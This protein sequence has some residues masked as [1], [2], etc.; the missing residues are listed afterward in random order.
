MND[1]E[2]AVRQLRGFYT[3]KNWRKCLEV[4][5]S[6]KLRLIQE[7]SKATAS[8]QFVSLHREVLEMAVLASVHL[9]DDETFVRNFAQLRAL[10]F[11]SRS[12]VPPSQNEAL[13]T[14]LNLLHLLADNR[15]AEFHTEM[16]LIPEQVQRDSCVAYVVQLEQWLMEGTYRN[17]LAARE[18]MPSECFQ[19][20]LDKLT[21][22]VREEIA[23]CSE[24]AYS[25]LKMDA[26]QS[27][28][29]I[30]TAEEA[31][32]FAAERQWEVKNQEVKFLP[33][34]NTESGN[35]CAMDVIMNSMTYARE[36]ERIV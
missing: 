2:T 11:D 32:T 17:V 14:G 31:R 1:A 34:D 25:S 20:F 21:S 28:L 4:V 10:Y 18:S 9:H 30:A 27:L 22:T 16:E 26:A 15:I 29:L 7:E 36:L 3:G 12:I 33:Q 5:P 8:Q 13:M 24:R 23:S 6:V 19:P 35:V